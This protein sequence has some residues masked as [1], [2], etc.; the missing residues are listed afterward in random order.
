[1]RRNVLGGIAGAIVVLA[2]TAGAQAPRT[3]LPP[4]VPESLIGSVSFDLYCASCHGRSGRGDGPTAAALKTK[5]A[6]L[7]ALARGNRGVFP[8]ERV[9]AFIEGSE[10]AASH[11][12]PEMPVWGPTLRALDASDA[13]VTVR[14][15]N[16]VAF[17]ESIQQVPAAATAAPAADGAA[18]FRSY[19]AN[20]HGAE[21]RGDGAMAGQ[22]R[23]LPPNLTTFAMRNGGVFPAERVRQVVDGT[24]IAAHG[25]RDMPVWGAVF[26]RATSGDAAARI[27]AIV[28]FLEGLQQRPA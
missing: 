24:G 1:M 27:D 10:R 17:V 23:R 18:L 12:S 14:L 9:L 22:L 21:G 4:L 13:R 20:C 28:R 8:R 15:Q 26:K 11:G 19:C 25:D 7:T 5:P 6:D 16:L 3:G 2:A